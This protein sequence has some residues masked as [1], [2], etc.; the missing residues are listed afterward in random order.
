MRDPS[1][2]SENR[3][4]VRITAPAQTNAFAAD[5]IFLGRELEGHKGCGSK[6]SGIVLEGVEAGRADK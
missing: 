6:P 3:T 4:K 5:C 2:S 1:G